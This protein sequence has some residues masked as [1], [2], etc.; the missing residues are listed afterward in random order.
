M[1]NS[2]MTLRYLFGPTTGAFADQNLNRQRQDKVCL[3]FGPDDAD[4]PIKAGDSWEDLRRRFP[5]AWEPD[6]VVLNLAYA[7]VPACFWTTPLPKV[8]LATDSNL[9]WHYFRERLPQ[10]DLVLSDAPAAERLAALG[11]AARA[12]K[13][14]G[15]ERAFVEEVDGLTIRPTGLADARPNEHPTTHDLPFTTHQLTTHQRDI[16]VLCI[17]NMNPVVQRDRAAWLQRV[18]R[19]GRR[20]RVS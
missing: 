2:V 15:C 18:A 19:L 5:D 1:E 9:L 16:D 14:C 10:C 20:W 11:I 6:F 3:T 7:T 17:G 13:L 12:A 8:A 4:V